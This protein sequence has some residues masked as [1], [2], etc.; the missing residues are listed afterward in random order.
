[1]TTREKNNAKVWFAKGWNYIV[2]IRKNG[3]PKKFIRD[4]I[5][6]HIA[7][8]SRKVNYFSKA[9]VVGIE[10]SIKYISLGKLPREIK[11]TEN[12]HP[13]SMGSGKDWHGVNRYYKSLNQFSDTLP[14]TEIKYLQQV[15]GTING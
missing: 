9:Y 15:I 12:K 1:M 10:T 14:E 7:S 8:Q 6:E 11:I 13:V 3:K 2:R 4:Q 5:E